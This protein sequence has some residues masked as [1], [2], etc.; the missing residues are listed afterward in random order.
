MNS[1]SNSNIKPKFKEL[2]A[3]DQLSKLN[4][5][6]FL[7]ATETDTDTDTATATEFTP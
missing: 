7:T 3:M 5:N 2:L 4:N 6:I 1:N